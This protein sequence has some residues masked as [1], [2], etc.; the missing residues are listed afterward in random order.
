M[1]DRKGRIAFRQSDA[2]TPL[3]VFLPTLDFFLPY[4]PDYIEFSPDGFRRTTDLLSDFS[5]VETKKTEP[6]DLAQFIIL[7]ET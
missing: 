4:P 1:P 7:K 3:L 6:T 5:I 2:T